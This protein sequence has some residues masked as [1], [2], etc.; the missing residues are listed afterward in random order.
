[1]I[2]T[3]FSIDYKI[4]EIKEIIFE[5]KIKVIMK[6]HVYYVTLNIKVIA[7]EKSAFA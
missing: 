2:K 5:H 6:N 4:I 7:S 1:M 3:V